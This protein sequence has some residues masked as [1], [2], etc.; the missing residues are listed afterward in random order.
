MI[1]PFQFLGFAAFFIFLISLFQTVLPGGD[2]FSQQVV[3]GNVFLDGLN[4]DRFAALKLRHAEQSGRYDIGLFG[5]SRSMDVG[6]RNLGRE[7][8]SFFNFSLSG[9]SLRGSVAMLEQLAVRQKL[10]RVAVVSVD[11]F[12]LQLYSNP[13]YISA[14]DRWHTGLR[15]LW[16]GFRAPEVTAREFLKMGWRHLHTEANGFKRLF[17]TDSFINSFRL[18]SAWAWTRAD[19]DGKNETQ[20]AGAPYR[21]DGSR[22]SPPGGSGGGELKILTP[23][24]PQLMPGYL[25]YD[26]LRLKRLEKQGV[27]IILYESP[28]SPNNAKYFSRNPSPFAKRIRDFFVTACGD[29][30]ISCTTAPSALPHPGLAWRDNNHAPVKSLGAYIKG[31]IAKGTGDKA[32]GAC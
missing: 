19:D 17:A 18:S 26:L 6:S 20:A 30:G 9:E 29:L 21:S 4:I 12:E 2:P 32:G 28:L 23:G 13:F 11:Y 15:D 31:L 27:K 14:I 10:P 7:T 3:H 5:N 22:V 16:W 8:C 25:R 24:R 1:R